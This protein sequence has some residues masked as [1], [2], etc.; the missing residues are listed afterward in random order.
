M[1]RMRLGK[2]RKAPA[3]R[4][5]Y[6]VDYTD[7]L[8]DNETITDVAA[9]GNVEEDEF[10][11]DGYVVDPNGREVVFFVSGGKCGG[12]YDVTITVDTTL[13][14]TKEDYVTFVVT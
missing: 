8:N 9:S 1:M 2:F 6:V 11:V 14:Q 13:T 5:R 3:D 7:W 12:E 10:Y 4:K